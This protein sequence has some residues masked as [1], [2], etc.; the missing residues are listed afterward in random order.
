MVKMNKRIF[1][2]FITVLLACSCASNNNGV[3]YSVSECPSDVREKVVF[4][5][6]EY[7][8]RDTFFEWGARDMLEKEGILEVDC[9]GFIVRVFQYAVKNTKYSLLFEDTNVS[10]FYSYFTIPVDIPTPGDLIF[11][12]TNTAYPT[13]M[14]IFIRRDNENIY[15]IDSTYKEDEGIDGVSLRYYKKDDPK[16]LQFARLLV[17]F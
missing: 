17:K 9:S 5:A 10:S 1:L 15:F 13:H 12:G 14:S 8:K 11:M 3:R 6:Q 16:F 7:V 2:V 4:Y